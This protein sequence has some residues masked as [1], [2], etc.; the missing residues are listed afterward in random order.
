MKVKKDLKAMAWLFSIMVLWGFCLGMLV[1]WVVFKYPQH[2]LVITFL[3]MSCG[4]IIVLGLIAY[5]KII[6]KLKHTEAE[7][8]GFKRVITTQMEDGSYA[9]N[10][11]DLYEAIEKLGYIEHEGGYYDKES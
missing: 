7:K 10:P 9:L 2:H 8:F 11:S 5:G 4:V 6:K 1:Q 3:G